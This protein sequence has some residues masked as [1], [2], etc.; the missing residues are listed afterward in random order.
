[1]GA[2]HRMSAWRDDVFTMAAELFSTK[3]ANREGLVAGSADSSADA[4]AAPVRILLIEDS[5]AEAELSLREIRRAGIESVSVR[6]ETERAL[7]DAVPKF[8]PN[9]ILSDFSMPLFDGLSALKVAR[10]IAP[11]LPFVFVSGTIGEERAIEALQCGAMDYVLKNNLARL[12]PA[13]RRALEQARSHREGRRQEAQIAHLTRVLRMLS[14]INGAVLRIRDRNELFDEACRLAVSVG[15]YATALVILQRPGTHEFRVV[16]TAGPDE[17]A[18]QRLLT[19]V[20][21]IPDKPSALMQRVLETGSALVSD[22]SNAPVVALPLVLDKTAI[23]ALV[24]LASGHAA[25]SEEELRML[26]E[27]AA[28]LSYALQYLRKGNEVHFLSY[29]DPLT[30]LAKRPLFCE[31]L[32]RLVGAAPGDTSSSLPGA[33]SRYAVAV[34]DI[35]KL[36]VINDSIGR[37]SGDRLLLL[38]TERLRR[39]FRDT[40]C[41]AQ[42]SGGT[43]AV[44]L[45]EP[46]DGADPGAALEE[47]LATVFDRP[48]ELEGRAI[49]L[50][51]KSGVAL[52]PRDG[53]DADSLVQNAEA[54]LRNARASGQRH[55]HYST[56]LHSEVV[57]QLALEHELRNAIERQQF[58][59]HYQPIMSLATRRIDGAEGLIRWRHPQSGL[60]SP[61]AFLPLL[62]STG[63]ILQ[64][65]SWVVEQAARDRQQWQQLALAAGR[66]AINV[67]PMELHQPEFAQR[68]LSRTQPWSNALCGLD[69]EI[70]EGA[71]LDNSAAVLG[72][73]QRLRDAGICIAIDDFGTGYS[74]LSRLSELPIDRLKIDRSFIMRLP[75]DAGGRTLVSTI[76]TL[77]HAFGM[78]VV[79]EG[80]ETPEQLDVLC[81]LGC[82]RVQGFLISRP[83]TCEAFVEL[84]KKDSG[85]VPAR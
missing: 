48:F 45:A 27:V 10:E 76:I 85:R 25:L 66:I 5:P 80:V 19:A 46:A 64:A 84:L 3:A 18:A 47:K 39:H 77:A 41:V 62:E 7:R 56:Q 59:L 67:S 33:Q 75:D 24:L 26:R 70:T 82:D 21:G 11:D 53:S 38:A 31:R 54:A 74:S 13:V 58:E 43:F 52:Y 30:G 15:G 20:V 57:A 9:I 34:L 23:G 1:M 55:R 4:A 12:A 6:V 35:E 49:P 83:V 51:V 63:L 2:R 44:A 36:S 42:F 61:A 81:D 68:F 79:A 8:E 69:I 17:Q 60:I 16:S 78:T 73:L 71:L 32:K 40:E 72:Q 22:D 14:G 28:N 29:F 50:M 37:H 65:G